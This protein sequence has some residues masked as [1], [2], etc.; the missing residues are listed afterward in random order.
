MVRNFSSPA[1]FFHPPNVNH[2][3]AQTL[4]VRA[5]PRVDDQVR[6]DVEL[7]QVGVPQVAVA[8]LH[9]ISLVEMLQ[10]RLGDVDTAGREEDNKAD[11]Q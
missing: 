7:F 2:Q 4:A 3:S 11:V 10:R 8:L 1:P 6:L 5:H 9:F